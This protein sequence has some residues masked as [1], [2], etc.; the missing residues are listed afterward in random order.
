MFNTLNICYPVYLQQMFSPIESANNP[1]D[2][3]GKLF[4]PRPH[5][6]YLKRSFS[7]SGATLWNSLPESLRLVTSHHAFKTGLET[8]LANNSSHT[9]IR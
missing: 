7:F 2:S 5:T 8:F 4:I 3:H 6:D 1:R 9:A